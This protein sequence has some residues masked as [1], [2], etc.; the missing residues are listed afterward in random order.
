M[1]RR[2]CILAG[3]VLLTAFTSYASGRWGFFLLVPP[4]IIPAFL[5]LIASVCVLV[6]RRG[7]ASIWNRWFTRTAVL[8]ACWLF[9]RLPSYME[10]GYFEMGRRSVAQHGVCPAMRPADSMSRASLPPCI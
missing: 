7:D 5:S 8:V 6:P 3:L 2:I 1:K 10:D 9:L 4:V